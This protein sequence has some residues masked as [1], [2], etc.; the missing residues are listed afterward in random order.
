MGGVMTFSYEAYEKAFGPLHLAK[1]DPALAEAIATEV[2]RH[3]DLHRATIV[4]AAQRAYEVIGPVHITSGY[5]KGPLRLEDVKDIAVSI[6]ATRAA[7][8]SR[9]IRLNEET[10]K[11]DALERLFT[12]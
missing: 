12:A 9:R 7:L 10:K 4:E 2:I 8:K 11:L 5:S 3:D 6:R 1:A